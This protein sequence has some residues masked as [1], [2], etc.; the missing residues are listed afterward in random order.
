MIKFCAD[1]GFFNTKT[2]KGDIFPSGVYEIS[3]PG[4]YS[5]CISY[6][7]R[8]YALGNEVLPVVG[9]RTGNSNMLLLTL[10]A[11]G[12]D[13]TKAGVSGNSSVI[14]SVGLPPLQYNA[15]DSQGHKIFREKLTDYYSGTYEF[16]YNGELFK[17][18]VERVNV[19]PQGVSAL[20][21]STV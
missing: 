7:G 14:L 6:N 1:V 2:D 17:I 19:Y 21:A 8:H 18:K 5:D 3:S 9:D 4:L 11:M 12:R 13:F 15:M 16:T 20:F 10:F